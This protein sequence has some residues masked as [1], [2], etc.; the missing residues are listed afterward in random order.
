MARR[1][2]VFVTLLSLPLLGVMAGGPATALARLPSCPGFGVEGVV[3]GNNSQPGNPGN[4]NSPDWVRMYGNRI[5]FQVPVGPALRKDCIGANAGIL[6]KLRMV[7]S[8]GDLTPAFVAV[9]VLYDYGLHLGLGPGNTV[10]SWWGSAYYT[11]QPS[12]IESAWHKVDAG[13]TTGHACNLLPGQDVTLRITHGTD[14]PGNHIWEPQCWDG[15]QWL[16][17]LNSGAGY[18]D[19]T[20]NFGVDLVDRFRA[21]NDGGLAL[22]ATN[23][24]EQTVTG[25][26]QT[27]ENT[28]CFANSTTAGATGTFQFNSV[29][30]RAFNIAPGPANPNC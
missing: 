9:G 15:A 21:G 6:L 8:S 10:E 24:Q 26:W 2:F 7:N 23:L 25:S 14:Q 27:W 1:L 16:P 19:N 28:D 17:M 11:S 18:V 5:T 12:D 4:I 22:S 30:S 13:S 3:G 20:H 29:S